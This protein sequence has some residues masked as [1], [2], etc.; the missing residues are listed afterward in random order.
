ML[1][2]NVQ[3]ASE[4]EPTLPDRAATPAETVADRSHARVEGTPAAKADAFGRTLDEGLAEDRR[5]RARIL[6]KARKVAEGM[7]FCEAT[8]RAGK[9]IVQRSW[10]PFFWLITGLLPRT[11]SAFVGTIFLFCCG[12]GLPLLYLV[13][14]VAVAFLGMGLIATVGGSLAWLIAV[15][16][17]KLLSWY[18]KWLVPW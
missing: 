5:H 12:C 1:R 15:C 2:R 9:T 7:R 17:R 16:T 13:G 3:A 8:A 18:L 6:R 11:F 14:W 4:T 10:H